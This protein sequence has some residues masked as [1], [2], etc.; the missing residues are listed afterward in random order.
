MT[1]VQN[2]KQNPKV[3]QRETKTGAVRTKQ[4]ARGTL[5]DLQ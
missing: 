4:A 3:P 1:A 5:L 2:N